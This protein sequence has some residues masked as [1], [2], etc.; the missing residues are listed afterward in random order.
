MPRYRL[1][2]VSPQEHH[3]L[4]GSGEVAR[5][6]RGRLTLRCRSMRRS[7]SYLHPITLHAA[8]ISLNAGGS[9]ALGECVHNVIPY[10]PHLSASMSLKYLTVDI[11][12]STVA[13]SSTTIM[14]FGCI[15]KL[16]TGHMWLTP[17]STHLWRARALLEPVAMITTS[18]A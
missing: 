13:A 16:E 11:L 9:L 3:D 8:Q 12:S 2:G 5:C 1:Y 17:P 10:G 14:P 6:I 4:H 18:R 15:C 7:S